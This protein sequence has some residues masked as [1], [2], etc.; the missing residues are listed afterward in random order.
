MP[1][2]KPVKQKDIKELDICNKKEGPLPLFDRMLA[3]APDL[4]E[5]FI[6]LQKAIV[7]TSIS[8]DLREA[9]ITFVS[10]KNGCEFCT[11]SHKEA[12]EGYIDQLDVL[13]WL[14]SY[15]ENDMSEE[16]KAALRYAERL[17][18]K[19]AEV[20]KEDVK[21]LEACGYTTKEIAEL[22]QII[23]YTSYTNQLSIGLGL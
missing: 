18:T 8:D 14:E 5:A 21:S 7:R 16:W 1:W 4:Y 13:N 22:N 6:P 15:T 12:L 10:M 2:I 17:I 9:M 11:N 23:A 3:N 19:P 20:T